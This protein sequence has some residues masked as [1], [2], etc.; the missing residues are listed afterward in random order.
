M[1][2]TMNQIMAILDDC[3]PSERVRLE[4]ALLVHLTE[5]RARQ[6]DKPLP[7]AKPPRKPRSKPDDAMFGAMDEIMQGLA[8]KYNG[9]GKR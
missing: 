7:K 6:E 9:S 4:A 5:T 3:T 2:A 8:F 1:S